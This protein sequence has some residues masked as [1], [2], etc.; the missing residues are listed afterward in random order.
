MIT[1]EV[2]KAVGDIVGNKG[3]YN[4]EK[5][6][7][8]TGGEQKYATA[9]Q[10]SYQTL[11]DA[12]FGDYA[13]ILK[14]SD[15]Q[16]ALDFYNSLVNPSTTSGMS[17]EAINSVYNLI[18]QGS[19]SQIDVGKAGEQTN[20]MLERFN[21]IMQPNKQETAALDQSTQNLLKMFGLFTD[22]N[23]QTQAQS[24]NL[25]NQ[26]SQFANDQS[27]RYDSHY[28]WLKTYNPFQSP[29]GQ[30][31]MDYY[32]QNGITAAGNATAAGAANN[33]GNI[34]SYAAAN[35]NRQQ[36]AYKNA[37]ANAVTNQYNAQTSQMLNTLQSLGVDVNAALQSAGNVVANNQ[38]YNL[39]ILGNYTAGDTNLQNV[40]GNTQ[41][42]RNQELSNL[43]RSLL[44]L[45][46]VNS[47]NA[48]TD[49]Q[50]QLNAATGIY[51][52]AMGADANRYTADTNAATERYIV[53]TNANV[54]TSLA[55]IEDAFRREELS[56]TDKQHIREMEIQK[57]ALEIEKTLGLSSAQAKITAES[58]AA[59]S[60]KYAAD[61]SYDETVYKTDAET[62]RAAGNIPKTTTASETAL[63]D[64]Y[65]ELTTTGL[66]AEM[67]PYGEEGT[68]SHQDAIEYL[69]ELFPG[70][71]SFIKGQFSKDRAA[72]KNKN[73]TNQNTTG[74]TSIFN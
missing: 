19:G 40:V 54:Q 27:G 9:A 11:I 21:K 7:L 48:T 73:T 22:N 20:D 37:G 6:T 55:N 61:R 59:G 35:A 69:A 33:S 16:Q 39:G 38:N 17:Q 41:M 63:T 70:R 53:N 2:Y 52:T 28:D 74:G 57:I 67:N 3:S 62:E 29:T 31:I 36:L 49:Y 65:D 60:R 43:G 42:A 44:G 34:D 10:P 32:N 64:Y 50:N 68:L 15:Y 47:N 72:E 66:P 46:E 71:A 30:S 4:N 51:N 45:Q 23:A 25:L 14:N 12:G 58:I 1:P 56:V 24:Q 26:I 18:G 5:Y 8:K 13:D